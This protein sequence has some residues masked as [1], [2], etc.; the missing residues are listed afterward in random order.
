[1]RELSQIFLFCLVKIINT[2]EFF[3]GKISQNFEDEQNFGKQLSVL[4]P[5]MLVRSDKDL[6][7]YSTCQIGETSGSFHIYIL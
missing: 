2:S 1:M 6:C 5:D 7:F 4:V 3:K